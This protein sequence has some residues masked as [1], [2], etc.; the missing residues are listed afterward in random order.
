MQ[1]GACNCRKRLS[2]RAFLHSGPCAIHMSAV[3]CSQETGLHGRRGRIT[4]RYSG[5]SRIHGL[6][7][8]PAMEEERGWSDMLVGHGPRQNTQ[9]GAFQ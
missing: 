3:S 5:Q 2:C 7:T 1:A 9:K 6:G 4:D 8:S